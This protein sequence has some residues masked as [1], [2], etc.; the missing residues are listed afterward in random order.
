MRLREDEALGENLEPI[1]DWLTKLLPALSNI[2]EIQKLPPAVIA[3]LELAYNQ[4]LT[5]KRDVLA[6]EAYC[7][8]VGQK[9]AITWSDQFELAQFAKLYC[10][11]FSIR[12]T[13]RQHEQYK[14]SR[15]DDRKLSIA[16]QSKA[17]TKHLADQTW[18]G[19]YRDIDNALSVTNAN[20]DRELMDAVLNGAPEATKAANATINIKLVGAIIYLRLL[21]YA[22]HPDLTL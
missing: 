20:I 2:P 7:N 16:W 22:Y 12:V 4:L 21:G 10:K 18:G 11:N 8:S 13:L 9:P 19:F 6:H 3:E 1:P 17:T 14:L 5:D 15:A